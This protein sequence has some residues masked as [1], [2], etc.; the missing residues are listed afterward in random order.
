M[1]EIDEKYL[2]PENYV[3]KPEQISLWQAAMCLKRI[4][5]RQ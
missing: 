3:K 2:K 4:L 1:P 5:P